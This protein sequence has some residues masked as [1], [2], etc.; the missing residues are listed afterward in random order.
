[1]NVK[2]MSKAILLLVLLVGFAGCAAVPFT[3]KEV[4]DYVSTQEQSYSYPLR[5]VMLTAGSSLKQ[6]NFT[7]TRM[8]LLG[9]SGMIRASCG[10]TKVHLRFD[11]VTPRLTRMQSKISEY[12][13]MRYFSGEEELFNHV[14]SLLQEG[15][16]TDLKKLTAK[17]VSIYLKPDKTSRVIAY[18]VPGEELMLPESNGTWREMELESGGSGY[19]GA[20]Y[21]V[22]VKA[23]EKKDE[24]EQ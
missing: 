4:K 6:L 18:I 11:S 9:E 12:E 24:I 14:R 17:M 21:V 13:A 23:V 19:I 15:H 10:N 22:Y 1:M 16:R 2:K 7:L 20:K 3:L 8:E 5:Q